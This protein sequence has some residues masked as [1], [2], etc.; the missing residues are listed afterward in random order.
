MRYNSKCTVWHKTANGYTELHYPCWWQDTEALNIS[1]SGKTDVDSALI[2]LPVDAAV[3]KSDYIAQGE[4]S[5]DFESV[6]ELLKA[7]APLKVTTVSRKSYGSAFMQ[8]TEVTA[9]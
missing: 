9:K 4:I 7:H 3:D 8:H 1:K 6:S 2:H 5:F